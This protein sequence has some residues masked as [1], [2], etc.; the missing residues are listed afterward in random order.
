MISFILDPFPKLT[1][2]Y[3]KG[4]GRKREAIGL[5]ESFSFCMH[6]DGISS[7]FCG[8]VTDPTDRPQKI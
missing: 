8:E 4:K 7:K 1:Q 3:F 6:I 5:T 2:Q